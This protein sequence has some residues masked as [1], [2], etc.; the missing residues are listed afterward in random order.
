MR[1]IVLR[2]SSF[3]IS[4]QFDAFSRENP[5]FPPIFELY[6][7][8][9]VPILVDHLSNLDL[10]F[11]AEHFYEVWT[12]IDD[13]RN[14]VWVDVHS[15]IDGQRALFR[16][17]RMTT[18]HTDAERQ[19]GGKR[20]YQRDTMRVHRRSMRAEIRPILPAFG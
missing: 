7:Y 12:G 17:R 6:P 15:A 4:F 16:V 8:R 10:I 18:G 2:K 9:H 20:R 14:L 11:R 13:G 1:K 5:S 19:G 3:V